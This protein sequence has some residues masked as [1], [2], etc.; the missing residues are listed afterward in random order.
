MLIHSL[1]SGTAPVHNPGEVSSLWEL[2]QMAYEEERILS[3]SEER[4]AAKD[5]KSPLHQGDCVHWF[6]SERCDC[7]HRFNAQGEIST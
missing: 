7:L 4:K 5:E 6:D 3:E 1:L 2:I